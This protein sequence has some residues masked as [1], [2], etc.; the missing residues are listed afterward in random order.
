[1]NADASGSISGT[2]RPLSLRA[3][4]LDV[5]LPRWVNEKFPAWSDLLSAHQVARLTRR[6]KW[7]LT[8]LALLG[9]FPRQRR[10]HGLR[11]GWHRTDIQRWIEGARRLTAG[12]MHQPSRP[13][14]TAASATT[15]MCLFGCCRVRRPTLPCL[16]GAPTR[17]GR[18]RHG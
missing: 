7:A 5:D 3:P 18:R 17:R 4:I 1:M 13:R 11:V 9:L 2:T 12:A 15:Q 16:T 8:T 14:R 6:P 10:F